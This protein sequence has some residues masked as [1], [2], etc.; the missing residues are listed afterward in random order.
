MESV[1]RLASL[2]LPFMLGLVCLQNS[3]IKDYQVDL[4]RHKEHT[5]D[6]IIERLTKFATIK[7]SY[8]AFKKFTS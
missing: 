7:N 4:S 2:T 6:L 1:S 8:E 5:G 3:R